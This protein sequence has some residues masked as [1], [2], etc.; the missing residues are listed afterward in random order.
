MLQRRRWHA[1]DPEPDDRPHVA[2]DLG[3][4][5]IYDHDGDDPDDIHLPEHRQRCVPP[6]WF[7]PL[8]N[9][10][11]TC[12]WPDIFTYYSV[13]SLTEI[14]E[15]ELEQ[16]EAELLGWHAH[17]PGHEEPEPAPRS[18]HICLGEGTRPWPDHDACPRCNPDG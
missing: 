9:G 4:F 1:G 15:L 16:A 6:G 18:C 5:W 13:E 14:T 7:S 17:Y 11:S 10:G 8:V 3:H 2:D 12:G